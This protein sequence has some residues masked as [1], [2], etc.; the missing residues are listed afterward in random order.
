MLELLI[1]FIWLYLQEALI[2]AK[3]G[4]A[5]GATGVYVG[6]MYTEYLDSILGPQVGPAGI[7]AILLDVVARQ[8]STADCDLL[9]LQ[10]KLGVC[11]SYIITP[12]QCDAKRVWPVLAKD[13]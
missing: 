12:C 1:G 6:C 9:I 8:C 13:W 7:W 11:H 10:Q 3:L 4:S 2:Q 5:S